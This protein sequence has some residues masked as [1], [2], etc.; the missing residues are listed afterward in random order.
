MK[1]DRKT[2]F[3]LHN[4]MLK[5]AKTKMFKCNHPTIKGAERHILFLINKL[6]REQ[7]ITITKLANE[8]GVTLAAVTHQI[9]TLENQGLIKRFSDKND[10]RIVLV[11]LTKKG[12]GEVAKLKKEFVDKTQAIANFLGEE[13]TKELVRLVKRIST[14]Q[15]L[16]K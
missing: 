13:D 3:E 8:I 15:G 4:A 1:T 7:S 9:N 5:L 2:T 14:F 10:K 12:I 16:Y 11:K 6:T